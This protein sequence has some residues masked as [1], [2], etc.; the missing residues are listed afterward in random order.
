[1]SGTSSRPGDCPRV[2][3]LAWSAAARCGSWSGRGPPCPRAQIAHVAVRCS[4]SPGTGSSGAPRISPG[5]PAAMFSDAAACRSCATGRTGTWPSSGAVR[6]PP[7]VLSGGRGGPRVPAGPP[8][9]S[10]LTG[11]TE[12][13]EAERRTP[14]RVRTARQGPAASARCRPTSP[15]GIAAA[16]S[17]WPHCWQVRHGGGW[18]FCV[19]G[20]GAGN[21]H[22]DVQDG[23]FGHNRIT[24]GG[25]EAATRCPAP[26]MRAQQAGGTGMR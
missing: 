24:G 7:P 11:T 4:G 13:L 15:P 18:K 26:A 3:V 2:R 25:T 14:L 19:P 5:E 21:G 22:E 12:G 9:R 1:M 20:S 16:P 23:S 6:S 10:P 17:G 8:R